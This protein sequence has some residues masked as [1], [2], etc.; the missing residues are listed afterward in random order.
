MAELNISDLENELEALARQL[1]GSNS[2]FDDTIHKLVAMGKIT[3]EVGVKK[4]E[5]YQQLQKEIAVRENAIKQQEQLNKLLIS[6]IPGFVDVSRA[7]NAVSSQLYSA[8][9]AFTSV[10]PA[11]DLTADV[12][13]KVTEALGTAVSGVSIFGVTMGEAPKGVAKFVNAAVEFAVDIAKVQLQ[14]AQNVTNSF[15]AIGS[16][17]ITFGGSIT[18]MT[19]AAAASGQTLNRFT[20]FVNKN[21]AVLSQLGGNI[22]QNATDLLQ[23]SRNIGQTNRGLLVSYG[24]YE[25]LNDGIAQ[26]ISLQQRLG[27]VDMNNQKSLTQGATDY[28]I[29]QRELT[30][31]TGKRAE[32]LVEEEK[33]RRGELDYALKLSTLSEAQQRNVEAT[34]QI[35]GRISPAAEAY[36][37]EYFATGGNVVSRQALTFEAMQGEVAKTLT[38]TLQGATTLDAQAFKDNTAK[39]LTANAPALEAFARSMEELASINRAAMNPILT[40]MATTAAGVLNNMNLFKNATDLFKSLIP[41]KGGDA[42]TEAAADAIESMVE[43]QQK[44]DGMAA[45]SITR[46]K[47]LT[48]VGFKMQERILSLTDATAEMLAALTRG[49][50]AAAL[51]GIAE[52]LLGITAPTTPNDASYE[53][54]AWNETNE[55]SGMIQYAA[56][57]VADKPVIAGEDGPE[58]IIPLSKGNIPMDIDWTPVVQALNELIVATEEGNDIRERILK[59]AY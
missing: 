8:K 32:Q 1:K 55:F 29:R 46:M 28:L 34:M 48:D 4:R 42:K 25:A 36:I 41:P 35:A 3:Y 26:Y 23:M 53:E 20:E 16:A 58:A 5:E 43:N 27:F 57:G 50:G 9:E 49:E 33:R 11:I 45:Q 44:L 39:V 37:K 7:A 51:T 14:Y 59:A 31:I 40:E 21:N 15:S 17:G 38:E 10:I 30:A 54:R 22:V 2:A 18:A 47:E 52:K 6:V 56:G 24:S 13:K 12:F 19:N